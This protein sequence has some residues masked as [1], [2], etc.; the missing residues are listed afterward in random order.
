MRYTN[1]CIVRTLYKFERLSFAVAV[2][3]Y[4][5]KYKDYWSSS[6]FDNITK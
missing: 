1:I 6:K 4:V 2:Q 3:I 5:I